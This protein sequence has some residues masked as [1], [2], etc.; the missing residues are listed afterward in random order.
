MPQLTI[1]REGV[2]L[3]VVSTG[4][5]M[6]VPPLTGGATPDRLSVEREAHA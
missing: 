5:H 3:R 4:H 2:L 1:N 6:S